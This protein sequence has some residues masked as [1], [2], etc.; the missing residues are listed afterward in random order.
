MALALSCQDAGEAQNPTGPQAPAI[1]GRDSLA[2]DFEAYLSL[3]SELNDMVRAARPTYPYELGE[4]IDTF[5]DENYEAFLDVH[6]MLDDL[7]IAEKKW[8]LIHLQEEGLFLRAL[9]LLQAGIVYA[10]EYAQLMEDWVAIRMVPMADVASDAP[11]PPEPEDS[12]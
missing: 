4:L 7:S 2:F 11:L 6:D 5:V 9:D 3:L 1:P 10:P 12:N 8:V